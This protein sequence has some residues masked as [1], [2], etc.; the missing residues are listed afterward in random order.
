[1]PSHIPEYVIVSRCKHKCVCVC[2]CVCVNIYIYI[3]IYLKQEG[4]IW[5]G[6]VSY[7]TWKE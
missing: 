4:G 2:V 7:L 5:T 6:S 3:Y 1:M